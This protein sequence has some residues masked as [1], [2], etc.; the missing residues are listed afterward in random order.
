MFCKHC[1]KELAENSVFCQYCGKQLRDNDK[2]KTN[3]LSR[4]MSL[5]KGWQICIMVYILLFLGGLCIMVEAEKDRY[6]NEEVLFPLMLVL[7]VAP[8]FAL[9][10]WYSITHLFK[11]TNMPKTDGKAIT[12][13][14]T[15]MPTARYSLQEFVKAFGKMQ[16]KTVTVPEKNEVMSYCTFT[17]ST[18]VITKVNF[19][20]QLGPL[21]ASEIVE[22]Q[23]RLYIMKNISGEYELKENPLS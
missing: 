3:V 22:R 12:D 11:T 13:S 5:G 9:F 19:D 8:T 17:S 2:Q 20:E 4:F 21:Q 18:G 7:I 1:G 15:R 23:N 6:F 16:I 10:V 14:E